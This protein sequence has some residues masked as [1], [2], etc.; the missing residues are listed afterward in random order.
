MEGV[1]AVDTWPTA[2]GQP[3]EGLEIPEDCRE[4]WDERVAIMM[5]EGGLSGAEAAHVV[6]GGG[7]GRGPRLGRQ[8]PLHLLGAAPVDRHDDQV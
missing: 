6:L 7:G 2:K 4:A 3:P 8:A 5:V 1:L